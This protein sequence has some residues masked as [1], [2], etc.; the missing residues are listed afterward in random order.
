[1]I[2]NDESEKIYKCKK[3][4][5]IISQK[6]KNEI[7]SYLINPNR[8]DDLPI[9]N[10]IINNSGQYTMDGIIERCIREGQIVRIIS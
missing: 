7:Y 4:M 1:M 9:L 10:A 8:S 2:T 3:K 6:I 5:D